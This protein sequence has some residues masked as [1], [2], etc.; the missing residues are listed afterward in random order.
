MKRFLNRGSAMTR[1]CIIAALA[2]IAW[3]LA[4]GCSATETSEFGDD[5][6]G[7]NSGAGG[8]GGDIFG[9]GGQ[10][11]GTF[12]GDPR[13]CDEAASSRSYIGCDFW[14]TVTPNNVWSVFDYA[15]VVAN[16]G[17]NVV[18]VSV[19]RGG[20]VVATQQIQPDALATI[21]LPWVTQLKGPDADAF[22]GA[23]PVTTSIRVPDGAYHLTANFPVTVYQ[24]NAL[25]Y[26]PVGG[27]PGKNWNSCPADGVLL[28]CF[29]YSNDA[30]LLLP[31]TAMTGNYRVLSTPGWDAANIGSYITITG[32]TDNTTV[33]FATSAT[34]TI[35]AGNG[36][37]ATGP[38]SSTSFSIGRGEAIVLL[39]TPT[40]DLSGS[41][42]QADN[43]VQVISGIPCTQV[44][45][46]MQACDHLEE[47]VFP[48]E[49]LGQ[50]YIVTP[51]TGPNGDAPGHVVRF[52]GNFDGTTLTYAGAAPPGAPTTLNA[53]Q[54]VETTVITSNF[55]VQ[56]DQAFG[57]VSLMPGADILDPNGGL[58]SRG[59]PAQSIVAAVEQYRDK[60][61]FLAPTDY[62]VNYVDIVM[63]AGASVTLDGMSVPGNAQSVGSGQFAINR[64]Q[65]SNGNNGAHTLQSDVPVGIQ[66]AGY[67]A[68]TSYYYP[69]GLNLK[70][71]A[72]PPIN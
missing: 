41:L 55:E 18:D 26:A 54:V 21:Y 12:I 71:I 51:P 10:G 70:T 22:G 65:L 15:V 42:L 69:G 29:S 34:A 32:I 61:I 62:D 14:P 16:T 4:P 20:N 13:T 68:Y 8:A 64:V 49:T 25:E 37:T 30:S 7:T 57:I 11:A 43:P 60:Y 3:S 27:P 40:G 19:E 53:G 17:D 39:T 72:P 24:F 36:V 2:V 6:T 44:P 28:E 23:M 35:V 9:T 48:A 66:V 67:G 1:A 31:S 45:F 59:D 33:N 46:G 52:Y 56:S 58:M 47:S 5:G 63:P 38:N 50:H